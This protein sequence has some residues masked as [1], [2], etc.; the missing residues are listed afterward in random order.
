M[1]RKK[2]ISSTVGHIHI[3]NINLYDDNSTQHITFDT[4]LDIR[5][6]F[7]VNKNL[8]V[9][10]IEDITD[11]DNTIQTISFTITYDTTLK[12]Y[13]IDGVLQKHLSLN[14]NFIYTF[15]QNNANVLDKPLLIS[16]KKK[17]S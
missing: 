12:K 15:V 7:T 10:S 1:V 17:W 2:A 6:D 3:K 5:E 8:N 16:E 4:P 11:K 9:C 14:Q 13:K